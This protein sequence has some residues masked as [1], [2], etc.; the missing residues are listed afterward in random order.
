MLIGTTLRR[1]ALALV[2]APIRGLRLMRTSLGVGRYGEAT[3]A[4]PFTLAE[5]QNTQRSGSPTGSFLSE[6]RA[7]FLF[8]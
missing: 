1:A 3:P 4:E 2:M 8:I 6:R 7:A 5:R